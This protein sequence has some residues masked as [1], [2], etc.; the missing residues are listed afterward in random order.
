MQL[1]QYQVSAFSDRAFCGNPAAVVSLESW[2]PDATM[3]AIAA[4][5]NLSETAFY[6]D[7]GDHFA[8]RWFTPTVEVELCGHA[9]LATAHVLFNERGHGGEQI[10]FTTRF[11]GTLTVSQDDHGIC[12]DFPVHP[13]TPVTLNLDIAKALGG[14]P[15]AAYDAP[16]WVYLYSSAS[17]IAELSPDLGKL[18]AASDK[19]VIVTA[20]G[21]V[22]EGVDFVSRFFGPQVGVDEDPVTGSAHCALTPLWA[23]TDKLAKAELTARQLSRRGGDLLC[24]LQGERVLIRGQARTF[25]RGEISI[26]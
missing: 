21:S 20:A 10:Q 16:C 7:Q 19:P 13:V 8:L 12:L 4:E 18:M 24:T 11:S 3:L 2:L 15:V 26:P 23:A 25:L 5:N 17:E 6:I 14:A 22:G 1:T 9:T